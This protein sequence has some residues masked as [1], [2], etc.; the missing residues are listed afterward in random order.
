MI[1]VVSRGVFFP[2]NLEQALSLYRT[3]VEQTRLEEGCLEYQIC[4]QSESPT[5][6]TVIETWQSKEALDKH[7]QSEHFKIYVPQLSKLKLSDSLDI[8]ETII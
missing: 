3:L 6:L 7:M 2:D 5:C 4:Q 1:R 8:Y